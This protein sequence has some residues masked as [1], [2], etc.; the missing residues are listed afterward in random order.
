MTAPAADGAVTMPAYAA[1]ARNAGGSAVPLER[2]LA[3]AIESLGARLDQAGELVTRTG[4]PLD[5]STAYY[6]LSDSGVLDQ[7]GCDARITAEVMGDALALVRTRLVERAE[8]GAPG[9]DEGSSSAITLH[10]REEQ[11][12][13]PWPG[14]ADEQGVSLRRRWRG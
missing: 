3:L 1:R 9:P 5:G 2:T 13:A 4:A 14:R 11:H 7:L 6:A 8:Q 10:V 12:T